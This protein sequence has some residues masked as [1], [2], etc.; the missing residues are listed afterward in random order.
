MIIYVVKNGDSLYKISKIYGVSVD[1][2]SYVNMLETPDKLVIGQSL[3]IPIKSYTHIVQRG[4]SI[5]GISRYYNVSI[6]D[7]LKLNT[8]ITNPGNI[9]PGEV[10]N[11]PG[12][13]KNRKTI[14]VNG[15][16]YANISDST[17]DSSLPYL[18]YIAPFSYQVQGDGSLARLQDNN[19]LS[20]AFS[21]NTVPLL[22][23]TNIKSTGGFDSELAKTILTNQNIQNELLDNIETELE[24]K[25][26][27]GTNIDFEY[28]YPENREDY[29][30]FLQ[31]VVDRFK[32]M[33]YLI[34]TSLAPKTS[35]N[36]QGT[37]YEAHDYDFHG[38][39]AD[40][41]IIMTYE[42]GYT[43]SSPMAVAPVNEVRKVLDYAVS[44]IPSSKILMG[45]SNYGYDWKIPYQKGVPARAIS[46]LNALNL[47]VK[48]NS[49]I[50]FDN[51]ASAPYFN[52]VDNEGKQHVVWFEDAR[53]YN[54]RLKLISEYNLGGTSIWT[55]NNLFRPL[56]E[57][58]ESQY[59]VYKRN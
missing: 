18:T 8:N 9:L 11:I 22:V 14:D 21:A 54:E 34:L 15:Y 45:L 42:W 46:N 35:K 33:G 13:N 4:E 3:I 48:N 25:D 30:S 12:D 19:I 26:F 23:I 31:R 58:L 44:A 36:Q 39:V 7:I 6:D 55:I 29:N 51:V 41:V 27:G 24:T 43:Y 57:I 47:A 59:I 28:I 2:I 49:A 10:L 38:S 20:R 37:L 40:K 16:A 17:L 5:Y 50:N 53:S 32:P 52:Y 56:F 1:E